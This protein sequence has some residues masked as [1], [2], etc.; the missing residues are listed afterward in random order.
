MSQKHNARRVVN[1]AANAVLRKPPCAFFSRRAPQCYVSFY[2]AGRGGGRE[3]GRE[4][5]GGGK[6]T[7][8]K[9]TLMSKKTDDCRN[10]ANWSIGQ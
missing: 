9:R 3:G 10:K 6:R 8:H 1:G 5:E 7:L 4:G 2:K